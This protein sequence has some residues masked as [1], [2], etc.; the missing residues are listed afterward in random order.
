MKILY[1]NID[2]TEHMGKIIEK[3]VIKSSKYI[4]SCGIGNQFS[5]EEDL[6]KYNCFNFYLYEFLNLF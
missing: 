6:I 5:F 4:I 3:V 2:E 1:E